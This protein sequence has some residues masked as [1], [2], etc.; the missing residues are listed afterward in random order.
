MAGRP[1]TTPTQRSESVME[2]TSQAWA[3]MRAWK[4]IML[5]AL[6]ARR[7]RNDR[8][9]RVS[10]TGT[11]V[12]LASVPAGAADLPLDSDSLIRGFQNRHA[13]M[14]FVPKSYQCVAIH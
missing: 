7:N 4:P 11:L 2:S 5:N 6:S 1:F 12:R 13:S 9:R 10:K 14:F 8:I 3:M